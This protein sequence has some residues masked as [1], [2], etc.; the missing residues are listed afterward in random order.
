MKLPDQIRQAMIAH[1]RFAHP[2]EACGLLAVDQRGSLRMAYCLT[3]S[4][5]SPVAFTIDPEEHFGA[6]THAERRGWAIGGV[7]HSHPAT[8][9]APSRTDLAADLDPE[10]LHFIV[11]LTDPDRPEV[12][13]WRIGHGRAAEVP[14]R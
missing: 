12:R 3:N 8:P 9:A 11:G 4:K 10:W 6:M 7:F 2:D 5:R 13:A 1:A 14:L